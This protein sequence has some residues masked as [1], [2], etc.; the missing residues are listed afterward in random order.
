M[1]VTEDKKKLL[2]GTL[3]TLVCIMAIGYA[4]LAQELTINGSA[5]IDST[6][7]VEITNI[8]SKDVVGDAVN[9]VDPS[10]TAT[11]ANFSVGFTQ[12]GDSITYDIKV[13]NKGTLDAVVESIN[14]VKGDNQAIT[15]TISGLKRGDKL[16]KNNG[17]NTLTVKVD[18][19]SNVTSQPASTTNDI[20]VTIN[21]QQDLGQVPAYEAYSIGDTIEFAGSNWRVIKNSTMDED[22][23]T[24]M[25]E[26]VLTNSQLGSYAY[27]E[28]YDTMEFTWRDNCHQNNHGY[29]SN[30]YSNCDNTNIYDDSKVKEMLDTRYLPMLG[31]NNLKEVDGYKIR[32]ITLNELQ[33]NLGIS[34][35]TSTTWY[36]IDKSKT[37]DWVYEP[38]VNYQNNVSGY[39]TMTPNPTT[40]FYVFK[41]YSTSVAFNEYATTSEAAVRPVINLL[42]SAI[43]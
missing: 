13:T 38:L 41:V 31:E 30:D 10:Y 20:T 15:Y 43:E 7:K 36:T 1:I 29:S 3:S 5:S 22:Y 34:K 17:T 25:K 37:P 26:T 40:S 33:E 18:Y 6:W 9:K 12:P 24:L 27:N 42:K 14:V 16:A 2:I 21:Y 35:A 28:T 23:V 8:E 11:T 32:L 19:D 39:W 4:L